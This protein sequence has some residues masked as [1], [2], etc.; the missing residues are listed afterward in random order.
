MIKIKDS[1][2]N[3]KN[4]VPIT[5]TIGNFDG[6][7][8][9]HQA[10]ILKT[11][12]YQD[13]QSALMT[14]DPHPVHFLTKKPYSQL[15][16]VIDKLDCLEAYQLDYVWIVSFDDDFASLSVN[17]FITFLKSIQVKR[18]IL[19]KDARFGQYGAGGVEDLK[20]HFEVVII[21]EEIYDHI[22]ISSSLVK[23]RLS[24][25][26][27]DVA[28]HLLSRNYRIYGQVVHGNHLG[29]TLGYPTANIEYDDYH[30][31]KLGV[32]A[33]GI[34]FQQKWYYG[35]AN[36][37]HNP[38]INYQEKPR[39]EIYIFDFN[40][41]LYGKHVAVEFYDYIRSEKKFASK[42]DLINQLKDDEYHIRKLLNH[43]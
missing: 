42:D 6:I 39:L 32:Y 30:I 7:H 14:F 17:D 34:L 1:Y 26:D 37:G 38:T 18:L 41:D 40:Q 8:L 29:R 12:S 33:V 11:T 31:P 27:M 36:I 20:S 13:T 23:T 22:R 21:E 16:S 43:Q 25:G 28:K 4:E 2:L 10:L 9:G 24:Q 5:L 35:M 3:I 19:G 15:M